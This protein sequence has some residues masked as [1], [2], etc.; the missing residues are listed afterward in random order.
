[1]KLAGAVAEIRWVYY[2][3][4]KLGRWEI[5][6]GQF[7]GRIVSADPYRLAQRPLTLVI[8]KQGRPWEWP[9]RDV[10]VAGEQVTASVTLPAEVPV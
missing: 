6:A 1:V 2:T 10:T 4:A 9:I 5:D 3:A 8:P 7:H